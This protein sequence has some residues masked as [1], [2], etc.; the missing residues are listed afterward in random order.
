MVPLYG[1][2]RI[3][4]RLMRAKYFCMNSVSNRYTHVANKIFIT[5]VVKW[6]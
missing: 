2:K 5:L 3:K 6:L 4:I 1:T